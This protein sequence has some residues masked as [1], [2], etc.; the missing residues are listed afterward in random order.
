MNYYLLNIKTKANELF[1]FY[2]KHQKT[3]AVKRMAKY[4]WVPKLISEV[5]L[6][7]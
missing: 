3:G 1:T 4:L 6:G 2:H 7:D 5:I